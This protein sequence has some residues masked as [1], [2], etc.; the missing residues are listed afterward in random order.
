[1]IKGILVLF[2]GTLYAWPARAA[3]DPVAFLSGHVSGFLLPEYETIELKLNQGFRLGF[4]G[5][6]GI[7]V[8]NTAYMTTSVTYLQRTG[9][10][11]MYSWDPYLFRMHRYEGEETFR[12]IRVDLGPLLRTQLNSN[13]WIDLQCGATYLDLSLVGTSV[14]DGGPFW[15]GYLAAG[16]EHCPSRL[17][18][19]FLGVKYR[20]LQKQSADFGGFQIELGFRWFIAAGGQD[21]E[22]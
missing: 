20:Y 2:L 3:N 6:L 1:M 21:S 12:E 9:T 13:L 22:P 7:R 16:L 17:A 19:V 8:I 11:S 4:G 14:D 15:G 18:S 10:T 5:S